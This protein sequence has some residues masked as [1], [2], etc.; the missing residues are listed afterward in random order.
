MSNFRTPTQ[1]ATRGVIGTIAIVAVVL[2]SMNF[3]K[4]PFVG[5]NDII[6][7]QFAE[8]GGLVSGDAVMMS[9]AQIGKVR[10]VKLDGNMVVADLAITDSSAPLGTLTRARI[11]TVTLL[12]RAAVQLVPDG[13]G[14]L[15]AGSTIPL[16]R[17]SSPYN[18][19]ADLNELTSRTTQ[20]DKGQLA[21][22]LQQTTSALDG[23]QNSIGPALAGITKLSSAVQNNNTQ[24]LQLLSRASRVTKVLASRN[25]QISTLLNSGNSLLGELN[26]R[27][28]VV[29][30]LLQSVTT[31]STQLKGVVGD[32]RSTIGPALDQL[33]TLVNVLNQ[34]RTALQ[35]SISGLQG[36]ATAFGEAISSGPWFDAY[37]QNLTSPGTLAPI[38]SGLT[39]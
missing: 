14:T 5:N 20:I 3:S 8:A 30:A 37:I 12:G 31:L 27:Q 33:D 35:A 29:V 24:L 26:A 7:A 17:T 32:N 9:G 18:L 38:L 39:K 28:D 36:Y 10:G 25:I 6:H 1:N 16:S 21:S 13:P 4:L 34:N 23:T 19:T 22:A 15:D 2:L 11:I